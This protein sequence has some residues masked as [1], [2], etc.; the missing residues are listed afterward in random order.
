MYRM[1]TPVHFLLEVTGM[2][3][4]QVIGF[5][6]YANYRLNTQMINSE[7]HENNC[8][9]KRKRLTKEQ[10]RIRRINRIKNRIMRA[11]IVV[12]F[13]LI[14][15]VSTIMVKYIVGNSLLNNNETD[16]YGN[17]VHAYEKSDNTTKSGENTEVADGPWALVLVNKSNPI[18][19]DYEVELTTLFN[20]VQVDSRIYPELQKMFDDM[21]NEGIYPVVGEGYRTSEMQKQMMQE[22]IDAYMA[23]G[24]SKTVAK[25]QAK[26]Y[27]AKAGTSEHE[28]GIA[29]DINASTDSSTTNDEV[30]QWL[31]D[32]AYKYGFILRYPEGKEEITG[33]DYEP[34][35]YR[36]V[37]K[38]AAQEMYE[39]GMTLEEYLQK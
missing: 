14:M 25:H 35:H 30:Y 19:S 20:G 10:K 5:N 13:F 2:Q 26:K 32:N 27:V 4:G 31:Y 36:Y 8:A 24:Y 9:R 17:T 37:G 22:K 6:D 34:W 11:L 15:C 39:S 23:E 33:I 12:M 16:G 7:V 21:R 18:P 28:L 29:L 38:Q 1:T 3:M